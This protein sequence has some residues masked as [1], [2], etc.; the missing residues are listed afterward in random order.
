[1]RQHA[2]GGLDVGH[3]GYCGYARRQL[4]GGALEFSEYLC[5]V[6]A[7]I[8]KVARGGQRILRTIGGDEAGDR[9]RDDECEGEGL[10]ANPPQIAQYFAM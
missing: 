2:D 7:R 3:A 5:E 8:G 4:K 6:V 10:A 1:M 9:A